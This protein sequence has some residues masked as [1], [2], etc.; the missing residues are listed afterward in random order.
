[1]YPRISDFIN[2]ILGTNF[3]LPIQSFGFFVAL[4]FIVAYF[5]LAYDLKLKQAAGIFSTKKI[6]V[7]VGG[8]ISEFDILINFALFGLLGYKLGLMFQDYTG[9]ARNPQE[10]ILSTDGSF[11]WALIFALAAGGYKL[12]EFLKKKKEKVKFEMQDHGI[13]ED[14]G[15][16]FTIA[17]IGGIL[18]AKVFHNL[19]YWDTFVKDPIGSLL[20][21]DGLTFYGGLIVAA[22]GITW[23]II[24][25][26]YPVLPFADSVATVLMLGYGIGRI[27]C[28]VAGDGDWGIDNTAPKPGWLSWAPDWVWSYNYPHNVL[29][30][31]IPI[32]GCTGD[33]CS[34]LATP[35]FPTPFYEVVMSLAIFAGLWLIRKRLPYWGQLMGIYLM[36]NGLERF[37][38]EKIRVN[39]TYHI[40][41]GEITQ[42]E[43]ISS[44]L[45]IGGL[46]LFFY[47]TFKWKKPYV[48]AYQN[49]QKQKV[50]EKGE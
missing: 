8:P 41:G 45:F 30:D 20:S 48:E 14:L 32:E 3:I 23:Y 17:F 10:A 35:V 25:K 36:F 44:V 37:F 43:I 6:K 21:F 2:D 34:V 33:Y 27:G 7:K 50:D 1:M 5:V 4:C 18:G 16:V 31:G 42:A 39:S 40:F 38:I 11:L 24:K 12:Y 9:F 46:V 13:I 49:P 47:S 15:T 19:E 26:N 22:A 28:Q 29:N